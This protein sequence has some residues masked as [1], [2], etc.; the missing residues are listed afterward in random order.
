MRK[1]VVLLITVSMLLA[2]FGCA[3]RVPASAGE[4]TESNAESTLDK[5]K[6]DRAL[7]D[8]IVIGKTTIAEFFDIILGNGHKYE[9]ESNLYGRPIYR[10]EC[11]DGGYVYVEFTYI[12]KEN[13]EIDTVD[14][15][16]VR[17]VTK[18]YSEPIY[19]RAL[20]EQISVGMSARE[21]F[22]LFDG[23]T[24]N[25]T[26]SGEWILEYKSTDGSTA[27]V[28]L[29]RPMSTSGESNLQDYFE[30]KRFYFIEPTDNA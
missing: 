21:F 23:D 7:F 19:D 20:L 13:G 27:V 9:Y 29:S 5:T 6:P 24:G 2:L 25:S 26:G 11:T 3:K 17:N 28:Y 18:E 16:V 22:A 12:F 10:F 4:T 8:A 1:T 15:E 14:I 30:V